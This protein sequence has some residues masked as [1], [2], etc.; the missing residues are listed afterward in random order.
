MELNI[1]ADAIVDAFPHETQAL[2]EC[3]LADGSSLTECRASGDVNACFY[4]TIQILSTTNYGGT[5]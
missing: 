2:F 3:H 1:I 5:V 4:R